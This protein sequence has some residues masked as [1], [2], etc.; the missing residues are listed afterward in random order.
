MA[1]EL[2]SAGIELSR[3]ASNTYTEILSKIQQDPYSD[4]AWTRVVGLA[5]AEEVSG[6]G[7]ESFYSHVPLTELISLGQRLRF[8]RSRN[9]QYQI[10]TER[11]STG[12]QWYDIVLGHV[13]DK[14]FSPIEE[15]LG[16]RHDKEAEEWEWGLDV[17][18][19]TGNILRAIAPYFENVVGVD[20]LRGVLPNTKDTLPENAQVIAG[21]A[22]KLPFDDNIFDIAVSNGLTH[23]LSSDQLRKYIGELARIL[24]KDGSYFESF[25]AQDEGS[26]LP[27]IEREYLTSAKALLVCL[28]DNLVSKNIKKESDVWTL[29]DMVEEFSQVGFEYGVSE[30]NEDGTWF[31][32]FQKATQ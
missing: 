19:G 4:E 18:A 5:Q 23:Y 2:S 10:L 31:I 22:V 15:E 13:N 8:T 24:K 14:M 9:E 7:T 12:E 3:P 6:D 30:G 16:N 25:I 17:G 28:L 20:T 27:N 1:D 11:N 26:P 21:D 32:E 29:K